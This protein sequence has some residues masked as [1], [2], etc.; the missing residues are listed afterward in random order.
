MEQGLLRGRPWGGTAILVKENLVK[1]CSDINTFDRVVTLTIGDILFINVYM[2]YDDG[3]VNA[4]NEL[5]EILTNVS[6]IIEESDAQYH[7]FGGDLN[8]D[9]TKNSAHAAAIN[10]FMDN[11]KIKCVKI[12]ANNNESVYTYSNCKLNHYSLIDFI[13]ISDSLIDSLATYNKLD[14]ALNHSDHDPVAAVIQMPSQTKFCSAVTSGSPLQSGD[15]NDNISNKRF[16][17]WDRANLETYYN[18]TRHLLYP[19]YECCK[20]SVCK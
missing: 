5:N 15:L 4:L 13:C 1:L 6:V 3:S 14:N 8:A 9:L 7:I 2:P 17:R 10:D 12:T 11:Y 16:L 19:I 18:M 20:Y